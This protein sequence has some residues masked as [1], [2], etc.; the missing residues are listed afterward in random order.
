M[1]VDDFADIP[2]L[3]PRE[4]KSWFERFKVVWSIQRWGTCSSTREAGE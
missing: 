1:S 4:K 2:L 3:V